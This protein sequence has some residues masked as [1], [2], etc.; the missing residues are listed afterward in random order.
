[1][2]T[3]PTIIIRDQRLDEGLLRGRYEDGGALIISV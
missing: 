2:F 3:E 1:M